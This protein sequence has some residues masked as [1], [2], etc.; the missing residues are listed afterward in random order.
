M[1]LDAP[2]RMFR[3]DGRVA[4]VTGAS[5]GLGARFAEVLRGAGATVV[6]AARREDRLTA[7]AGSLGEQAVAVRCDVGD[8]GDCARL[9]DSVIERFGRIDVLINN[10]GVSAARPIVEEPVDEFRRVVAVNLTAPFLLSQ[11]AGAHMVRAG[12]GSII[13]IASIFG[14]VGSAPIAQASYCASKG[15]L[16]NMTREFG[17]QWARTGVRVNALAPG[18]FE[19][20]MT[21]ADIFGDQ[22]A[23]QWVRRNCPMGR[24]GSADELDGA[25]LFLASAASSYVTG[26]VLTVDGGWTAR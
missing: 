4:I 7:L 21:E 13:N 15:A 19:S 2:E 8:D 14:L 12:S 20:E 1:M 24:G 25:L 3:L 5:S 18:W 16:V 6:L 26:Q 17:L 23:H 11:L 10:A 9:V 22:A